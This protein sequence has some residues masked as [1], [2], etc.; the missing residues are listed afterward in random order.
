MI[1][2]IGRIFTVIGL[3]LL[4]AAWLWWL[5][6]FRSAAAIDCLYLPD[7]TCPAAQNLSPLV[8]LPP[9][10]PMVLWAGAVAVLLGAVLRISARA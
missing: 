2:R 7:A 3:L 5:Y 4:T 10:E 6:A 8:T 9:Y 1:G